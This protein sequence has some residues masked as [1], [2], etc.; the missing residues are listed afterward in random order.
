M[1]FGILVDGFYLLAVL[2]RW[3]ISAPRRKLGKEHDLIVVTGGSSGLGMKIC[4]I[5]G[6]RGYRVV[7][8]DIK[9]PELD[10][11]NV[12]FVQCDVSDP[13]DVKTSKELINKKFGSATVLVNNAG[14]TNNKTVTEI[15]EHQIRK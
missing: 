11:P 1:V 3:L 8:L 13:N 2:N 7:N 9:R 6:I 12:E 14:I 15:D 5:L 10:V 4:A